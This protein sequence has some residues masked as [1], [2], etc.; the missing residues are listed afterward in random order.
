MKK[1]VIFGGGHGMSSVLY[2][3]K[4]YPFDITAVVTTTDSGSST[5]QIRSE[6]KVPAFG[7]IRRILST[8]TED[9]LSKTFLEYRFEKEGTFN[10]HSIGN[11]MLAALFDITKDYKDAV[12]YIRNLFNIR[13]KINPVTDDFAHIIAKCESGRAIV[14]EHNI[15]SI[16]DDR[17]DR[18]YYDSDVIVNDNI[19]DSILDAD[20]LIFGVGSLYTSIIPTIIPTKIKDAINKSNAKKMYIANMVNQRETK[21][22][23]VSDYLDAI[24]KHLGNDVID[25]VI[26][27]SSVIPSEIILKYSDLEEKHPTV[28]DSENIKINHITGDLTTL[29]DEKIRYDSFKLGYVVFDYLMRDVVFL[30]D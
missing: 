17:I 24:N 15:E 25:V 21:G 5:G 8:L 2:G 4:D 13:V 30:K 11:L 29:V 7:D 16:E 14:C 20:L 18:I 1:I 23:K 22:Y 12:D 28:I 19:V 9:E 27:S 6:L 10:N 3:L 26:T